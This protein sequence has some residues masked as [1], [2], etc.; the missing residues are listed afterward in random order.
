MKRPKIIY[1]GWEGK[2]N[3]PETE[4]HV[5]F[6]R[7]VLLAMFVTTPGRWERRFLQVY[8]VGTILC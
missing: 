5:Q 6:N 1:L 8:N 4:V 3:E 7:L 2:K